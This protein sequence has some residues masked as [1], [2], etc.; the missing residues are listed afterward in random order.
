MSEIRVIP[1][2]NA[3][4]ILYLQGLCIWVDL[5]NRENAGGYDVLSEEAFGRLLGEPEFRPDAILFTHRHA[6]HYS[7]ERLLK[8]VEA[9]P[10]AKVF[11][12]GGRPS[13]QC[14]ALPSSAGSVRLRVLPLPHAGEA[15]QDV[16]NDALFLES[17]DGKVLFAGDCPVACPELFYALKALE[18][19]ENA[20]SGV[21]LV[22]FNF[23]WLSLGKGR[24]ALSQMAP[25]HVLF[26]HLP[27]WE[28]DLFH[29]REQA[30]RMLERFGD[31]RDFRIAGEP[32]SEEI[33]VL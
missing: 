3:G 8:A 10:E 21:D 17:T 19:A 18:S 30:E 6:D 20:P 12:G 31:G 29:Y 32:F 27:S 23:P 22:F 25:G 15:Y 24:K 11:V 14:I 33:F 1:V 28:N 7:E 13:S 2:C 26:F 5:L 16:E 4:V 9:F